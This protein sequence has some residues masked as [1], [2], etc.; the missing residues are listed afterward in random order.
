M[1]YVDLGCQK[2]QFILSPHTEH[3][4]SDMRAFF[5]TLSVR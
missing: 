5:K 2:N 4:L 3:F 1:S